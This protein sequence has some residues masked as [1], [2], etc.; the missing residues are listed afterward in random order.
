MVR[1]VEP[2]DQSVKKLQSKVKIKKEGANSNQTFE[3]DHF[4]VYTGVKL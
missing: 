3:G 2:D 1:E 4:V